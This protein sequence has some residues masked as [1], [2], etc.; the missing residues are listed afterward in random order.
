VVVG[1]QRDR[2]GAGGPICRRS[3]RIREKFK[4]FVN[5]GVAAV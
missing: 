2:Q 3:A 4:A 5:A 1:W